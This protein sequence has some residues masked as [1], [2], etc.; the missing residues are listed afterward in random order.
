M[1]DSFVF[2]LGVI[3]LNKDFFYDDG[4]IMNYIF[5]LG[6]SYYKEGACCKE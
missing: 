5:F 4:D 2:L 6:E 3:Y 1:A